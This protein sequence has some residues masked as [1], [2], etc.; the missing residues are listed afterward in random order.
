MEL[1][2]SYAFDG[3]KWVRPQ[4][5][6]L[7]AGPGLLLDWLE[8]RAGLVGFARNTD[9]L[10]MELYRQCLQRL[11]DEQSD[12]ESLFFEKSYAA[13]RYAV[14]S[15]LLERRDALVGAGWDFQTDDKAPPRL[16]AFAAAE[17]FFQKKIN[18]PDYH[19]LTQGIADRFERVI[20]API[21]T[22]LSS[23]T[24][25]V[26]LRLC[27]A[28]HRRLFTRW[29]EAGI[30]VREQTAQPLAPPDTD[31][32]VFQ[33]AITSEGSG[34][35]QA[36]KPRARGDGSLLIVHFGSDSEA[37]LF[38]GRLPALNEGF[39][40]LMLCADMQR[41]PELALQE[42][43]QRAMGMGAASLARPALQA[44]RLAPAFLWEPIDIGKILEF[45]SLG[46]KPIE[47]GL[48]LVIA[49][50]LAQKPG[51]YN[52][53]WHASVHGYLDG[54][55][56][57]AKEAYAFWFRR[58]R[59]EP[60]QGAPK[61][62]A[63]AL[64][65]H[66][67]RWALAAYADQSD[68]RPSLIAMAEQA[69]RIAEVLG[70]MPEP[71][72]YPLE[73]E[74]IIHTIV[75][76]TP[77]QIRA[78]EVGAPPFVTQPDGVAAQTP[79]L[80]W[81]NCAYQDPAPKP[82]AWR[83]DE[84]AWLRA[85]NAEPDPVE[86]AGQRRRY[87]L[88]A[89]LCRTERRLLL[90]APA[91]IAGAAVAPSLLEGEIDATFAG[92]KCLHADMRAADGRQAFEALYRAPTPN[93]PLPLSRPA[94]AP[95][96]RFDAPRDWIR[97]DYY[98]PTRLQALL[99]YPHLW[100]F[101]DKLRLQPLSLFSVSDGPTL[102]GNLSHRLLELLLN[103]DFGALSRAS[104]RDWIRENGQQL[105]EQEGAP[106]L[107]Y[108]REPERNAFFQKSEQAAN[109][110][111]RHILDNGWQVAHTEHA[112]EGEFCGFPVKAKSDLILRRDNGEYAILDLKWGGLSARRDEIRNNEDLQL[113]LYAHLFG[114]P[115]TWPHTGYFII[116]QGVL[117]SRNRRAF[118]RA[119]IA[120]NTERDHCAD[121]KALI[122][123]A[124]RTL[125]WRQEQLREGL[126]EIRCEMT[127]AQLEE[128]YAHL[129]LMDML[130][131]RSTDAPYDDFV[132]LYR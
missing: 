58:R 83:A 109:A 65:E 24:L 6:R 10:R 125:R 26:P 110:L 16:R 15:A 29:A 1:H 86:L 114:E 92:A 41:L 34:Q 126:L 62:E 80:L 88:N 25:Y 30:S 2:F 101:S 103:T 132:F 94:P 67:N 33:R 76:P 42:Q 19:A 121:Y 97:A 81:W 69:R 117:V 116:R 100:F 127:A 130:E 13:N 120:G 102:L 40:P 17:F 36:A 123:M 4:N 78:A 75:E 104:L 31:L 122:R 115:D 129:D 20:A 35:E 68:K 71:R 45:V 55:S 64:F 51:L 52:D 12:P 56:D 8:K 50:A 77:A 63:I 106:L 5:G 43:G 107:Q 49:R 47:A 57:A 22:E 9:Y 95:F 39:K 23:V 119:E 131:M 48:S 72:V 7:Y 118:N 82:D 89:A 124:E 84:R 11:I 99:Y 113:A 61:Q 14:A 60:A 111:I 128:A 38:L 37:A 108:G 91:Q 53:V 18:E 59:Y 32:G 87:A 66:L 3:E 93:A 96:L 112:L 98:T 21:P 54:A 79:E 28:P 105:I 74:R 73:L 85:R 46:A 90:F 44:L 70:A 27:E